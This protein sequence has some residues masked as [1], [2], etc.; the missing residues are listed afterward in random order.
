MSITQD[1]ILL[2]ERI[3]TQI[4]LPRVLRVYLPEQQGTEY[5]DDFGLL[6]LE[7]GTVAPFYASLPGALSALKTR[8][9]NNEITQYSLL[10]LVRLYGE[11]DPASQAL[12]LGAFNAMSQYVMKA[13]GFLPQQASSSPKNMGSAA[14]QKGEQIGMVGYFCPLIDKL[15]DRGVNVL[16]IERVPERVEIR[17]GLSLS[18]DAADLSQCRLVLCTAATLINDS[19]DDIL[20]HCQGAE[21]FSLIGPSGSGLPDLLFERG[22]DSVGGVYFGNQPALDAKLES[23]ESWGAA[24]DKYQLMPQT[25]PGF[26]ALLTA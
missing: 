12:G 25:Y 6:F 20:S 10:D 4:S 2:A 21:N 8:F 22:V 23:R 5:R 18:E 7:G 14:P 26:Q 19:I 16:V 1:T 11:N 24:G 15:L 9:S 13:S 3:A 17:P